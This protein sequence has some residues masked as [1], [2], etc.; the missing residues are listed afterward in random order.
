MSD[1][2]RIRR[3]RELIARHKRWD[4]IFALV[5]VLA[6]MIG[7]LTFVALFAEMAWT[8]LARLDWQ[9]FT[10]FPSRRASQAGILS[11]WVGTSLVMLVTA[12]VAVPLG[13]A[14]GV[15][16]EEYARK[17]WITDLIEINITNLA[18]VPSIIYGLLALGLFVYEFGLGQSILAAGLTLALLIL[19]VVI[20]ATREA[21][22]SIPQTIR[23]GAYALG[24]TRWQ[25]VKD[26][27]LPYSTP[28]ILTGVIIGMARAI[29][30]TA[31]I[32][33]IGALTF[34]AFLPRSPVEAEPPFL[35]FE[36]LMSPFTV[37][38]IQMFNWTSRPEAA[39]QVNAAAAGFVLVLMTLGMNGLAIYIRYRLR[40]NLKW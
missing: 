33:T 13:V 16:L 17:N 1:P 28:G 14:S 7:V 22:R 9:F 32:I 11:A 8:G 31:P 26:H 38:P 34:I 18:G 35:N 12:F 27:I 25:T 21:I 39:F 3:I 40:K 10:S 29:G 2:E 23:E 24:A 5:G 15:Y 6:L 36:W 19:P 30:E 20:V 4:M 37:M